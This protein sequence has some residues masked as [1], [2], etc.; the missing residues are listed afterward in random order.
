MQVARPRSLLRPEGRVASACE[1][2]AVA[3]HEVPCRQKEV[4]ARG[5]CTR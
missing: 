5:F 2:W 4:P 1:S 3:T